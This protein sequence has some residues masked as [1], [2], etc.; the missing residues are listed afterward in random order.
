MRLLKLSLLIAPALYGQTVPSPVDPLQPPM[1][2]TVIGAGV[3][4]QK[5]EAYPLS[6]NTMFAKNFSVTNP[7]TGE[8][9]PTSWYLWTQASTPIA[10][11][12]FKNQPLQSS[13]SAGIAFVAAQTPGGAISV[14]PFAMGGLSASQSTA[15]GTFTGN[16]GFAFRLGGTSSNWYIMPYVGGSSLVGSAASGTFTLSPGA[17]LMYGFRGGK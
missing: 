17:M 10:P 14:V 3:S 6:E 9:I 1:P 15:G 8:K 11:Q 5:G 13:L 12:P 4:W 16:L 2:N 7:R